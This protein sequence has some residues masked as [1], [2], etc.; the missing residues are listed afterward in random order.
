MIKK[1]IRNVP[2]QDQ[3]PDSEDIVKKEKEAMEAY[4]KKEKEFEEKNMRQVEKFVMIRSLDMLW[5]DHLDNMDHLRD[6]VR[7]RAYG[8]KDP[9]IE[10][11]NEGMKLFQQLLSS[12]QATAVNMIFNVG[13]APKEEQQQEYKPSEKK[14]IGRNDPCHCGSGKKFKKCCGK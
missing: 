3:D 1:T 10:Y 12:I 2:T 4:H 7:L 13:L 6:S 11:K 9:L 5:M 14:N 8:Q